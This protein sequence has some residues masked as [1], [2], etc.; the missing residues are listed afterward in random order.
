M[1]QI[2]IF[3]VLFFVHFSVN[4]Q[5]YP[6]GSSPSVS[7]VGQIAPLYAD[8]AGAI[9][10]SGNLVGI[11]VDAAGYLLS[12]SLVS[13]YLNGASTN[14]SQDT[15]TAANS[16]PLPARLLNAAGGVYDLATEA[17]LAAASAKLPTTLGQK[18]MAASFAVTVASDQS[19]IATK[20]PVNTNGSQSDATLT[21]TTAS[22]ET[23]PANAVGFIIQAIDT[24]TNN[25]RWRV[26]SAASATTGM[27]LQAG[28]D[29]GF[30]P[31]AANVSIC[32]EASGT[33]AYQIQ[34]ILSQ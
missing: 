4:A 7:L 17:T 6:S 13:Y 27:Q 23:V 2:L 10:P 11:K 1:K 22:T 30:V 21:A 26:G 9:N 5:R 33:N 34:W 29:S 3:V 31:V 19:A 18:T 8:M 28:R 20:S 15:V 14:V 32:A 16:R 24:N 25:I 12:A